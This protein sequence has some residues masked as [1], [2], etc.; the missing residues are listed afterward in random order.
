MVS[1]QAFEDAI[2]LL[3]RNRASL[4]LDAEVD[5]RSL[6]AV[7]DDIAAQTGLTREVAL[8][9]V[10]DELGVKPLAPRSPLRKGVTVMDISAQL[11]QA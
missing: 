5:P 8:R 6:V 10:E 9:V 2:D 1:K 4:L 11:K 3:R 7:A